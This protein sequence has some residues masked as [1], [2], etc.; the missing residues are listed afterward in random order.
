[1]VHLKALTVASLSLVGGLFVNSHGWY[2][3]A[4]G[5]DSE[6]LSPKGNCYFLICIY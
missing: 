3:T 2:S 4:V 1:M 6:M 5:G